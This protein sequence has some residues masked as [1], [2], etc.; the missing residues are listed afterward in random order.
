[1]D[2]FENDL[3]DALRESGNQ[4]SVAGKV[5]AYVATSKKTRT[6]S[7]YRY[8]IAAAAVFV[9]AVLVSAPFFRSLI[10][11]DTVYAIV[12]TGSLY[13]VAGG[14]THV[15]GVGEKIGSGTP[16]RTDEGGAVLKLPDGASIEVHAKSELSLETVTDGV[17]IRLNGGSLSVT[18]AKQ[19]AGNLYVQNRGVTVPV[20]A[21]V[22]Q[23]STTASQQP[24]TSSRRAGTPEVRET[25]EVASIR[26][27]KSNRAGGG[28]GTPAS[29]ACDG[30][31]GQFDPTRI[32][33]TGVTL[34]YLIT[35][36]YGLSTN[37][38]PI[39]ECAG[40]LERKRLSGMPDWAGSE[41]FDLEANIPEG[42]VPFSTREVNPYRKPAPG[43]PRYGT[44]RDPGPRVLGML[45]VL[46]EDRFKLELR[47]EMREY[48]V[49]LLSVAKGGPKLDRWK[50][51]TYIGKYNGCGRYEGIKN[52]IAP[53]KPYAGLYVCAISGSRSHMP[54]LAKQI[55]Y[56]TK[57][58]VVLDRTGLPGE[59]TY[60]FFFSPSGIREVPAD[61]TPMTNP[62]LFKAIEEE[63]GLELKPAM[64]PVEFLVVERVQLPSEN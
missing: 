27:N 61:R 4:P 32:T 22:F 31:I 44:T 24:G 11:P 12:E 52:S 29:G 45:Q 2:P 51:D 56:F 10:S 14:K 63:L 6:V 17:S 16:V 64:E 40:A 54:W 20:V 7:R 9:A 23:S 53:P 21:T 49:Y 62:S 60:E 39:L 57:D 43:D 33:F 46:L 34:N 42:P 55:E 41:R 8:F 1:M 28:R 58:H 36:A 18:P 30:D 37:Y 26:I 50:E 38:V 47:R 48:P 35:L 19:P 59:F 5:M 3:R 15:L 13:R 25:F